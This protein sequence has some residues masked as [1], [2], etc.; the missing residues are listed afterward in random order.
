M[1]TTTRLVRLLVLLLL[2]LLQWSYNH[3]CEH[4][5]SNLAARQGARRDDER[6]YRGIVVYYA[7][8]VERCCTR[9]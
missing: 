2:L 6:G 7:G 8:C 9:S 3:C 1:G 5:D 4:P